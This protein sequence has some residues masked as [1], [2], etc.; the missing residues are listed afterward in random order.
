MAKVAAPAA[1]PIAS[2]RKPPNHKLRPENRLKLAPTRNKP[3]AET[4]IA[5]P[6]GRC[7]LPRTYGRSGT[8]APIA[9]AKNAEPAAP[10]GEPS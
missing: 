5:I 6:S 8:I 2:M 7:E 1:A 3:A 9:N 4:A 10:H